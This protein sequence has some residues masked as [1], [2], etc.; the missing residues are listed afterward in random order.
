MDPGCGDDLHESPGIA[1]VVDAVI[2]P[3]LME[4]SG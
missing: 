4:P 1:H 3:A 2:A